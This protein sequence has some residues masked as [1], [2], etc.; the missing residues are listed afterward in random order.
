MADPNC[1]F[2]LFLANMVI[3]RNPAFDFLMEIVVQDREWK[4]DH[5]YI[6]LKIGFQHSLIRI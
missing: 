4:P 6:N 2:S 5:F 3:G 1:E